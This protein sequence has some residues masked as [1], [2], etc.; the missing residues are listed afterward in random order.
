M[1][2]AGKL[3]AVAMLGA[4]GAALG[5]AAGE[6]LF[7][8]RPVEE[9]RRSRS[10]CMV[11]DVSGSM[12]KVVGTTPGGE[13][14]TQ[15]DALREAAAEFVSRCD[16]RHESLGLVVFSTRGRVV[17]A[18]GR[19]GPLLGRAIESLTAGGRTNLAEGL[20]L[21]TSTLSAAAGE[22]WILLFSDGRPETSPTIQTPIA[23]AYSAALVARRSGIQIVAIGTDLADQRILASIAGAEERVIPARGDRLAE[24]FRA[25]ERIIRSRQMLSTRPSSEGFASSVV[26]AALWAALIAIGAA[27]GLV[28]G[29]NGS[30]RRRLIGLEEAVLVVVGGSA[31][32]LLAGA[33]GQSLFY[34]ASAIRDVVGAERIAAWLVLGCGLGAGMSLVV[35]NLGRRRA[36]CGGAAGGLAAAWFFIGFQSPY[37][38]VQRLL[39]AA[40]LGF[41]TGSAIVLAEA[42]RKRAWL[43][44]HWSPKERSTIL[45]GRRSVLIG[46]CPEAHV[47]P[48]Y[49]KE[50]EP[51]M[52]AITAV[53]GVITLDDLR[54]SRSRVLSGGERLEM[55]RVIV[56]VCCAGGRA[57]EEAAAEADPIAQQE[58]AGS[59]KVRPAA[60]ESGRITL[61]TPTLSQD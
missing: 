14:L 3:A 59:R 37:D 61:L 27:A 24:A 25:S 6:P 49:T 45:L 51:V 35:P 2:L 12:N 28:T 13:P 9:P 47:R 20:Q 7:R 16:M 48:R 4:I 22:R 17:T 15:L 32:G 41:C 10:I 43:V 34:V 42:T 8:A 44:V 55:D 36:L 52:A 11:F 50:P 31:V 40:L 26:R 58:T 60:Q 19:D 56:E 30:L 39:A 46:N 57:G 33:C 23:A 29:Q 5:A 54:T 18:P 21:A 1:R 38:V 53:D